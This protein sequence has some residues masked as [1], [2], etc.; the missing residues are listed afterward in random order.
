MADGSIV[1]SRRVGIIRKRGMEN[2][3]WKMENDAKIR[4]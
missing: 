3:K 2:G 1:I 4:K